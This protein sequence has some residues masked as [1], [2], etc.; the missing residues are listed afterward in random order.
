MKY[1]RKYDKFILKNCDIIILNKEYSQY[2]FEGS[3]EWFD[4]TDTELKKVF[5]ALSGQTKV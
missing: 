4:I 5:M 3:N 2:R 1:I